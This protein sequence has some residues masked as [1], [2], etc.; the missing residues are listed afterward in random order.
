MFGLIIKNN[1]NLH[2]I[3][4]NIRMDGLDYSLK[5]SVLYSF[6]HLQKE[7]LVKTSHISRLVNRKSFKATC[8]Y[9]YIVRKLYNGASRFKTT[10]RVCDLL[11]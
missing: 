1:N 8:I 7:I 6:H 9:R 11:G 3:I 2:H 4:F 10:L 5:V